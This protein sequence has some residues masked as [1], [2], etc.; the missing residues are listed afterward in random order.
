MAATEGISKAWVVGL[1]K[2]E[3]VGTAMGLFVALQSIAL[4]IASAFA[5]LIWSLY[6]SSITFLFTATMSILVLLF[7]FIFVPKPQS[8]A[9]VPQ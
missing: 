8:R 6:G 9:V 3:E 2:K 4:M 7:I 1:V 5:G